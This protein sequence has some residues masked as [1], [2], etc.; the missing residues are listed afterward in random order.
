MSARVPEPCDGVRGKH[1]GP[2]RFFLTGW[3]CRAHAPKPQ[4]SGGAV[5]EHGAAA[6]AATARHPETT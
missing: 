2:V 4:P 1:V 5:D 6:A 3:K